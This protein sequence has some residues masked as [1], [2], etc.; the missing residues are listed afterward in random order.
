MNHQFRKQERTERKHAVYFPLETSDQ[1]VSEV[2]V[3]FDSFL[4][5]TLTPFPP[6]IDLYKQTPLHK[7]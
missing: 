1:I 7:F 6:F 4:C 3:P 2:Q 5:P